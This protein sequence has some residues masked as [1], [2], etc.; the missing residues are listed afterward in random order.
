VTGRS[1]SGR[2]TRASTEPA[3]GL[4][5]PASVPNAITRTFKLFD[6]IPRDGSIVHVCHIIRFNPAAKRWEAL[7]RNLDTGKRDWDFYDGVEKTQPRWCKRMPTK[8]AIPNENWFAYPITAQYT[9][10]PK[11]LRERLVE[12]LLGSLH[13]TMRYM[14]A[15]SAIEARSDATGTGAAEGESATRQG[16]A[17]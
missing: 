8:F 9:A 16:D 17:Q 10:R 1:P 15:A 12:R 11:T 2:A 7:Y 6:S 4:G 5:H 3:S 14:L 13:C